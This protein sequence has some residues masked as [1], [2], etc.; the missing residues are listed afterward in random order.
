MN[1]LVE[2][3]SVGKFVERWRQSFSQVLSE[4][5]LRTP[6]VA[7]VDAKSCA[8][9]LAKIPDKPYCVVLNG[10]GR[11]RGTLRLIMSE[12]EALQLSLVPTSEAAKGTSQFTEAQRGSAAEMISR[13]A[14]K[15]A[16]HWKPGAAT[17]EIAPAA[18]DDEKPDSI[19][20]GLRL[21][22]ENFTPIT[23]VLGPS[24]EFAESLR[25]L[26][27]GLTMT[28][29]S[30]ELPEVS[31]ALANQPQAASSN[32]D[33]L[34]D[35]QLE[36]TI[37]FGG[38]QLLLRDILSMSPG[39]VIGLDRQ[40]DEPAELLVAGRLVAR[41]EVVV[42]DGNFGLRITEVTSAN[43]RSELLHA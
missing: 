20:G 28:N 36:A 23:I 26:E 9:K 25:I 31:E 27:E 41:G 2:S 11:L 14:G 37:R 21:T 16:A 33:L 12:Q 39:S 15:V 32:L 35:V 19:C 22:A 29:P 43:Q 1:I 13:A 8:D 30:G 3:P 7:P 40:V 17:L 5:G 34:F 42:V 18:I 6:K 38:R 4:A 24:A 10:R